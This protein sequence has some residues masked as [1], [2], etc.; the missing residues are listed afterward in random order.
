[1]AR[2]RYKNSNARDLVRN[3][4]SIKAKR[5]KKNKTARWSMTPELKA[6]LAK[7]IEAMANGDT[8]PRKDFDLTKDQYQWCRAKAD[9]KGMAPQQPFV[10]SFVLRKKFGFGRWVE[11]PKTQVVIFVPIHQVLVLKRL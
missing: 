8:P 10:P 3:S 7:C 11:P 4:G 5:P 9:E 1:M 6:N 2:D